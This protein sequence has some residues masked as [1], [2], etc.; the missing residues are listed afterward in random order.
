MNCARNGK[1][2][3]EG[4]FKMLTDEEIMQAVQEEAADREPETL[5]LTPEA[6]LIA[7]SKDPVDYTELD[8]H[9][10][11]P[12]AR[13]GKPD[14]ECELGSCV[15]EAT[16]YCTFLSGA[17]FFGCRKHVDKLIGMQV[18]KKKKVFER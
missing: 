1:N 10:F 5:G 15:S 2:E 12:P 13:Q 16:H 18:A 11:N 4:K 3:R 9:V 6:D 17:L 8:W 7:Q 14:S